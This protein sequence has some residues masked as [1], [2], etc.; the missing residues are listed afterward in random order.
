MIVLAPKE[1]KSIIRS[2]CTHITTAHQNQL[3]ETSYNVVVTDSSVEA[4]VHLNETS[5]FVL[6]GRLSL[7][8]SSFAESI[9]NS[10]SLPAE[11]LEPLYKY[12]CVGR[13][14][15]W[16]SKRCIVTTAC[17]AD[18]LSRVLLCEIALNSRYCSD[19]PLRW[20]RG[21]R[22]TVCSCAQNITLD[23]SLDK[24]SYKLMLMD[25][26]VVASLIALLR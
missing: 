7:Q 2:I 18:P 3:L 5:R 24:K 13:Y 25:K 4:S 21:V 12:L 9:L 19:C 8:V 16:M 1:T 20:H 17:Q 22:T 23:M 6:Y 14:C 11:M 10:E 26:R 15:D